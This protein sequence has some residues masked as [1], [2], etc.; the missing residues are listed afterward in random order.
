MP[1]IEAP[2]WNPKTLSTPISVTY[3]S[4]YSQNAILKIKIAK[5]KWFLRL[6]IAR[7]WYKNLGKIVLF[8]NKLQT[9]K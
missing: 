6:L 7:I 1:P 8:L 4:I 5:I 2:L 3:V 9:N